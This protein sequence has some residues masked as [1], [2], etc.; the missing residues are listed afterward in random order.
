MTPDLFA[1]HGGEREKLGPQVPP[2]HIQVCM[3]V[4]VC[5]CMYVSVNVGK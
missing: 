5:M 1:I 4:Y 3:C 2:K